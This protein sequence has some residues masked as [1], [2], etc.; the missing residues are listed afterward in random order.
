MEGAIG[1]RP[2]AQFMIAHLMVA[3]AAV[4]GLLA[5]HPVLRWITIVLSIP[6]LSAIA[7]ERLVSRRHR[8]LAACSFWA[9]AATT[10]LLVAAACIAPDTNSAAFRLM[11]PVLWVAALPAMIAFGAA[12][13]LLVSR[14]GAFPVRRREVVPYLVVLMAVLPIVT[15]WPLCVAFLAV[16]PDL[17]RL[18]DRVTASKPVR[19]PRRIGPFR[20]EAP[21]IAPVSGY[22]GLKVAPKGIDAGFVRI[23]AGATPTT[24][25]PFVGVHFDVHRGGGWWYCG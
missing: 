15:L 7:A 9:V 8:R 2:R 23:H 18:A 19:Y 1:S 16:R 17:D 5:M 13:A 6:S 12:W 3:V 24:H 20:I 10:N 22:V 11:Q 4:A 14:D 21:A 25:G